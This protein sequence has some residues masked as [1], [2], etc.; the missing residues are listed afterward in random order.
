M[1]K[2][3]F[4]CVPLLLLPG[5]WPFSAPDTRAV[6][7]TAPLVVMNVLDKEQYDDAH[8][9]GSINVPF[10]KF[11]EIVEKYDRATPIV[12][13]CANYA[14]TA[15]SAGAHILTELGFQNVW[16][17]EG[18]MAEWYQ[19]SKQ[20]PSYAFEGSATEKYLEQPNV[21]HS[22]NDASVRVITASDLQKMMKEANLI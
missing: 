5:C 3:L 6:S 2:A 22:E 14:C 17:Y 13:Y 20:D 19:L 8:I 4:L 18:G 7:V 9:T 15:S 12:V 1:T 10:E 21:P 11:E 16:A